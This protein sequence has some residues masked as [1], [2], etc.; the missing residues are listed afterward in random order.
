[1]VGKK[2]EVN[3]ADKFFAL[4]SFFF[5][6]RFGDPQEIFELCG[7]CHLGGRFRDVGSGPSSWGQ[8]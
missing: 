1:M 3:L 7:F 2:C 8:C 6:F 4:S 5:C